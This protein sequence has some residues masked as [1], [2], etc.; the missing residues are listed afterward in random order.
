MRVTVATPGRFQPAFLWAAYLESQGALKRLV[1]PVNYGRV[2]PWG[3]SR[4]RTTCLTP[5]GALNWGLRRVASPPVQ[6]QGQVLTLAALDAFTRRRVAA[7]EVFNGW[8]GCSLRTIRRARELG[9]PAVLQ[10]GSAHIRTQH[11]LIAREVKQWGVAEPLPHPQVV[12]RALA[13]YE[14]AD[15]IVA[16]SRFARETFLGEGI[17]ESKIRV[18]PWA[19]AA[20][21]ES[22]KLRA[23]GGASEP[24][25]LFVGGCSLRKGVPS[26]IASAKDL[27]GRARFRL[28][29]DPNPTLFSRLGGLPDNVVA[30]GHRTGQEL[31]GEFRDADMFVLPSIEDGSALVTIEAMLAGLPVVVSDQAGAALIIEGESGFEF[32]AGDSKALTERLMP[33]LADPDLRARMGRAAREA[34]APR[35]PQVYGK[36]LMEQVYEPLLAGLST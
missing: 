3:V 36:E 12:R 9:V 21:H 24:T 26:L 25:V 35:T 6:A 13:E 17:P 31:A 4:R 18:V 28:V 16:P 20:V 34:A 8:T 7:G 30:V 1:T 33:L 2:E 19:A 22:P 32:P 5:L 14:E 11:K 29:G 27:R 10:T 23:P 15:V